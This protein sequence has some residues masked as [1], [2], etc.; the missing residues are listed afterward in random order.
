M[1]LSFTGSGYGAD[2]S[3]FE[4]IFMAPH[5]DDFRRISRIEHFSPLLRQVR[6]D[7]RLLAEVMK[8]FVLQTHRK[9]TS[10]ESRLDGSGLV[11]STA[12]SQNNFND[13][14]TQQQNALDDL[15]RQVNELKSTNAH[16][17]NFINGIN[18]QSPRNESVSDEDEEVE[19]NDSFDGQNA[20]VNALEINP[21]LTCF[22]GE[23]GDF[24]FPEWIQR[25]EDFMNAQIPPW[26]EA[27]KLPKLCLYLTG[28]AR[29][30]FENLKTDGQTFT[31]MKTALMNSYTTT[32]T[33]T[34]AM[35]DLLSCKQNAD[36]S[37]SKFLERLRRI[38]KRLNLAATNA[39][40]EQR[41]FDEFMSRLRDDIAHPLRLTIPE[42][43]QQA[44]TKASAIEAALHAREAN[45][46]S[47]V[48]TILRDAVYSISSLGVRQ[49]DALKFLESNLQRLKP[50]V[51]DGSLTNWQQANRCCC[52]GSLRQQQL[53][54]ANS[55][56]PQIQWH[57]P[58]GQGGCSSSSKNPHVNVIQLEGDKT[59]P[60]DDKYRGAMQLLC[61][62]RSR[63]LNAI[64]HN[65]Q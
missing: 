51:Q 31:E 20:H 25:F 48:D 55:Q 64:L 63:V 19:S 50:Q 26:S 1:D 49:D 43:L 30:R 27:M 40:F 24:T 14:M 2:T 10:I 39:E 15:Q 5:D 60:K 38:V 44:I 34:S 35:T 18:G 62:K 28:E 17:D 8:T 45:R 53:P 16:M 9:I 22:S 6:N 54:A 59:T 58:N 4:Q 33:R 47:E 37:V 21:I 41:L 56:L 11:V 42:N 61:K 32:A 57:Q 3:A 13:R 52:C 65:N 12:L 29:Q 46:K 7:C 36:E 23:S